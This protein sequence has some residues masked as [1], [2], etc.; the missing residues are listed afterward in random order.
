MDEIWTDLHEQVMGKKR[1]E[2]NFG[3]KC[4]RLRSA[5]RGDHTNQNSRF[6]RELHFPDVP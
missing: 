5:N 4:T 1:L 2:F 3:I 6:S